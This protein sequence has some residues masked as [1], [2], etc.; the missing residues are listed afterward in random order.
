VSFNGIDLKSNWKKEYNDSSWEV[1]MLIDELLTEK[2][3]EQ[4]VSIMKRQ[5]DKLNQSG[6]VFYGPYVRTRKKYLAT[7]AVLSGFAPGKFH[8]DGVS[9]VDLD[10]GL[11]NQLCQPELSCEKGIFHIYSDG[12]QR[13]GL[14]VKERC[15]SMNDNTTEPPVFFMVVFSLTKNGKLKRV[16]LH[17]PDKS[18]ND[19]SQ[20]TI[21]ESSALK[22]I[23]A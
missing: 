2:Q 20:K 11:N 6:S 10:Y 3:Q 7:G 9:S 14:K 12:S 4:I 21:W 13:D 22:V 16:E 8:V 23:S 18:G 17:L 15:K 19:V 1:Y 5:L